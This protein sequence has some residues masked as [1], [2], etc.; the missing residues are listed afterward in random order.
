VLIQKFENYCA[1]HNVILT[2]KMHYNAEALRKL[3]SISAF[4]PLGFE[5][6]SY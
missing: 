4:T 1:S 6:T 3:F 5:Q 2:T